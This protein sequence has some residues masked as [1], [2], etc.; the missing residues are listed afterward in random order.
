[1]I[2]RGGCARWSRPVLAGLLAVPL[3]LTVPVLVEASAADPVPHPTVTLPPD[4]VR[5]HPLFD[6][7]YELEPF[8]YVEQE[9]FVSGMARDA[10]GNTAPY[11][12]RI[13]VTRPSDPRDFNGTAVLEWVNVTAQFENAVDIMETRQMLMREGF[14]YVHASAQAAGICCTPLTPKAWDPVRYAALSHPGDAFANDLFSQVANAIRTPDRHPP[15]IDPTSGLRVRRLLA[16][17]QSQSCSR[18]RSYVTTTQDRAG[19]ADGFLLH[20]C[21][22]ADKTFA[23]PLSAKI[24]HLLS[25]AEAHP[26]APDDDPN[27]RLWEI[28]GTAHSDFFIGY[29][30]VVG[31]GP[32]TLADTPQR[33]KTEYD[34]IMTSAGNYGEQLHPMLATCIVAGSTMPMHY[35]ASSAIYQLDRWVMGADDPGEDFAPKNGPR[36]EFD[37]AARKVDGFGN[38]MG[39][40]RMPPIDVPVARYASTT[41]PLGG[42]TVPFSDVEVQTLYPTH[43]AYHA[44]MAARTDEAVR[45]GWLL[46]T[47]AIDLIDRVCAAKVRWHDLSGTGCGE[48]VP[49]G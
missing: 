21:S 40:I 17:G 39:G 34:E 20:G 44:Q 29:Q 49:P 41:C 6:S 27:Y 25:D 7:W 10:A 1:M 46:P 47:D 30:S 35:A 28:A 16:V 15:A 12:T 38:T 13:I 4:G 32:R 37:G 43:G 23:L 24:L 5:S 3:T 11:T 36:F 45:Q 2:R 22:A 26:A 48:Y 18:L 8:G 33:T 42:V 9:Y 19:L 14:M 31:L